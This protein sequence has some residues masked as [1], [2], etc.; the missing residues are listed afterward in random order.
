MSKRNNDNAKNLYETTKK[1]YKK[2]K[3]EYS[4]E[5]SR[6]GQLSCLEKQSNGEFSSYASCIAYCAAAQVK[7]SVFAHLAK[8]NF[9]DFFKRETTNPVEFVQTPRISMPKKK[10]IEAPADYDDYSE[11]DIET[12]SYTG[13]R[14]RS[15]ISRRYDL[16][17]DPH[18]T[19]RV[20]LLGIYRNIQKSEALLS[21]PVIQ[22]KG[23]MIDVIDTLS[24]VNL[25]N[26]IDG[27]QGVYYPEEYRYNGEVTPDDEYM[28]IYGMAN[29]DYWDITHEDCSAMMFRT[30]DDVKPSEAL[31]A[32]F[33]GPTIADCGSTLNGC[34]YQMLLNRLGEDDFNMV[35]GNIMAKFIITPYMFQKYVSDGKKRGETY[36][37]PLYELYDPIPS[38]V[39]SLENLQTG[40]IVYIEGVDGYGQKHLVGNG[41]GENLVCFKKDSDSEILFLGFGPQ[42]FASGPVPYDGIRQIL[43][44]KYNEPQNKETV[45]RIERFTS[46]E[47]EASAIKASGHEMMNFTLSRIAKRNADVTIPDDS[48]INGLKL[49][50]RMKMQSVDQLVEKYK[51]LLESVS[52]LHMKI[53]DES[54]IKPDTPGIIHQYK[55]LTVE[56]KASSFETYKIDTSVQKRM[57]DTCR[58]FAEA[59]SS[60]LFID[61]KPI[62]LTLC[63]D[64][65]IGKTHLGISIAKYVTLYGR[66]VLFL[67]ESLVG[68]VYQES[69]GEKSSFTEL[70]IGIDL[71]LFDDVNGRYGVGSMV[72]DQIMKYV[73]FNNKAVLISSNTC[74]FKFADIF[75]RYLKYDEPDVHNFIVMKNLTGTS[76]RTKEDAFVF[77][78]TQQDQTL[79]I[80]QR[81]LSQVP[82]ST[83]IIII[84][85]TI[86]DEIREKY[87]LRIKEMFNS[88]YPTKKVYVTPKP[89]YYEK[90]KDLYV[91]DLD[92]DTYDVVITSCMDR[93]EI[94]QFVHLISLVHDQGLRIITIV[95]KIDTFKEQILREIEKNTD[96][97]YRL[98]ERLKV[99]FGSF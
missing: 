6:T 16:D 11:R 40:D 18:I 83:N 3:K 89:E 75:P 70:F 52:W 38:D 41:P 14:S 56:N 43:V 50:M 71:I 77:D 25:S 34:I 28:G 15:K 91:H 86:T 23:E 2:I 97:S 68:R 81:K 78:T 27:N 45:K 37:N 80:F 51:T 65:G 44:K 99:M 66:N 73:V 84:D 26:Q 33:Y 53:P 35:F 96:T 39:L 47:Y 57:Y 92:H 76:K 94:E 22:G 46:K 21:I 19:V 30:N 74:N 54:M 49:G 63:G 29:S 62:G 87:L 48:K 64:V 36:G 17:L 69:Q 59:V 20:R 42:D 32:F 55:K 61:K 88:L 4:C 10:L 93:K 72:Y 7:E 58:K 12:D 1:D 67:D 79:D 90:I 5:R 8:I 95:P 24:R 85:P 98:K 31:K 82:E 9:N 60:N 13:P